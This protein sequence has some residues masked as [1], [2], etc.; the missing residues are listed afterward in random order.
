MKKPSLFRRAFTLVEILGAAALI[1]TLA[2]ISVI[3]VK[4]SVAAGQRASI[5]RE[6]QGLNTSLSNFKSAG[7]IIPD[8]ATVADAIAALQT[9]VS[10]AGTDSNYAPLTSVPDLNNMMIGGVPYEYIYDPVNGFGCAPVE[11]AGETFTGSGTGADAQNSGNTYPFDITDSAA[12]T[13][14]LDDFKAMSPGDAGYQEYLD[15]FA[16]AKTLGTLT[17]ED[18]VAI[19][20]ALGAEGLYLAGN[21]WRAKQF[22]SIGDAAAALAPRDSTEEEAIQFGFAADGVDNSRHKS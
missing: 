16:A 3:S 1:T 20:R 17:A 22:N 9:G 7:G 8:N 19:D 21:E 13:R 12:M 18:L 10:I 2:T 4:D 14:A 11:G 15:A 5:Q 6:L